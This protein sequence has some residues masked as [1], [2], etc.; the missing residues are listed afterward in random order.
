MRLV[1]QR[2][3]SASVKNIKTNE[4]VGKIDKGL[5]VLVGVGKGDSEEGADKLS[6]KLVKIRIMQDADAKMNLSVKDTGSSVLVVSQ[7]TLY[8]DTKKGNRPSFVNAES[9]ERAKNIYQYFVSSIRKQ[10]VKVSSGEFGAYME[11][12]AKLDGPVT[13][14]TNSKG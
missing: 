13:I 7:F 14:I 11:I 5:F 4:V 8:A 12:D 3:I 2:V 6:E 9:P 1:I 10:G